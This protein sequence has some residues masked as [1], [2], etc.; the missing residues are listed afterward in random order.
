MV[1]FLSPLIQHM[2]DRGHGTIAYTGSPAGSF[3]LPRSGP[4]SAAKAAGRVLLDSARI[5]LAGT[6]VRL[7]ALYPGFTYT[8]SLDPDEVPVK[9][10]IIDRERAARE[11]QHAIERRRAH[12]MFPKRIRLLIGLGAALP[13]W[14]RRFVLSRL[15]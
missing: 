4:Y 11:M 13:E 10:L 15:G 6:G 14:L 12:H 1:L 8:D 2:K 7:V 9:A 3:G 5:E